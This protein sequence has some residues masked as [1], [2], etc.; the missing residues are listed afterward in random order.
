[1][2]TIRPSSLRKRASGKVAQLLTSRR[3]VRYG[4][5]SLNVLLLM[6]I[7]WF[8]LGPTHSGQPLGR[9]GVVRSSSNLATEPLDQLSSADI[10]VNAA[11]AINWQDAQAVVNQADS[12][13]AE[14]VVAPADTTVIAKPQ[15]VSTPFVNRNDIKEYKVKEGDTV[16]RIA[17]KFHVTSDSVRW[18]NGLR[19][20]I[21]TPGVT[22]VIPPIPGIVYTV[23]INDTVDGLARKFRADRN[24]ILAF[25]DI[26]LTGLKVG[27]R[28]LIP[29]GSMPAPTAPAFF[30]AVGGGNGYVRGW[31][32]WYA[33]S[34]VPVP[35]NWGNANTWDN[36]A[37]LAGWTVSKVPVKGAILQTDAGWAGHVGIV[38]AVSP[39]GREI[40]YSDM[41]GLAGFNRVGYSGW[42]PA[43]TFQN[44]IYR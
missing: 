19:G 7:A 11:L 30:A 26:E 24:L 37:R 4:L 22:L 29:G 28:I 21:V 40:K 5:V 38:E 16:S 34:R 13:R 33:A 27:E 2:D 20:N 6:V 1:M 18:S 42:V 35:S 23:L 17:A 41:N 10:A 31:C 12:A 32:T 14:Q 3:F 44:Y 15:I 8:T 39:D 43:T 36:S 25:N 9:Q